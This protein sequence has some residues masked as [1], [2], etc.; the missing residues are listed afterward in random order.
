MVAQGSNEH[1]ETQGTRERIFRTAAGMFAERGYPSVSMR[2]IAETAGVSKPMLYYY[3][4]SKQGLL[5][6]LLDSGLDCM[7][8]AMEDILSQPVPPEEKLREIVRVR[9][10]FAREN[11]DIVKF[12]MDTFNDPGLKDMVRRHFERST[13]ILRMAAELIAE[14]QAKGQLRADVDPSL[15]SNSI[16]GVTGMY[17]GLN[18]RVGAPE[19]TDSLA[20]DLFGL[21]MDGARPRNG[22]RPALKDTHN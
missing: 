7:Q 1:S 18:L 3:F 12:Y 14:G 16:L 5:E 11:P 2:E 6:A 20:D 22:D 9:F 10:R 15:V 4:E 19:L 21:L 13:T 8:D 17:M